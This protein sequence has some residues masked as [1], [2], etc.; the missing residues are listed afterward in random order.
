VEYGF[1]KMKR[2]MVAGQ[3]HH[4]EGIFYG[5]TSLQPSIQKVLEFVAPEI[6]PE[7][8]VWIDVHTGLGAHGMDTVFAK[9]CS[10]TEEVNHYFPSVFSIVTPEATTQA[11]MG[12]YDVT[13]GVLV[14]Y[15]QDQQQQQG[16][17]GNKDSL[18]LVHEFGTSPALLVGRSLIL[19][20]QIHHWIRGPT[21][22]EGRALKN[23]AEQK[24]D[25]MASVFQLAVEYW[26]REL[27]ESGRSL[28][29]TAFYP[30]KTGWRA[31]VVQ[32]GVALATQAM[33][34]AEDHPSMITT[35]TDDTPETTGEK[36]LHDA[37][38]PADE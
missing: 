3:Y 38:D 18:F 5:G 33:I 14:E 11:A 22:E 16:E 34:Y 37:G 36:E 25:W 7:T 8:S 9:G 32:R 21:K 6:L 4:P 17:K 24:T 1:T 13:Q 19:E 12:G 23:K 28:M 15:L 30:Q 10:N 35:T 29:I 27:K 31:S 20:N 2:S 26:D